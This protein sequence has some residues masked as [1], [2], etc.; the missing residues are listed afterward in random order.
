MFILYCPWSC[1][2]NYK[3]TPRWYRSLRDR[4]RF[5]STATKCS[6]HCGLTS[7]YC[8]VSEVVVIHTKSLPGHAVASD[9]VISKAYAFLNDRS[10]YMC[11]FWLYLNCDLYRRIF[12]YI[13]FNLYLCQLARVSC[14][15]A[16]DFSDYLSS[17]KRTR[18]L[19][20]KTVP[21][22]QWGGQWLYMKATDCSL[23]H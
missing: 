20:E 17:W 14:F 10:S 23:R 19:T 3:V 16:G 4:Q 8:H 22:I 15:L 9:K 2:Y 18:C 5:N 7:L 21:L 12:V 6:L 1:S 11:M 13:R